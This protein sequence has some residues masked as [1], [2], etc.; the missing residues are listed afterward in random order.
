MTSSDCTTTA[1]TVYDSRDEN[2]YLVQKLSD[3]KCWMLDNLRLGSTSTI[4]LTSSNTNLPSGV[5]W[6]LPA[7]GSW[8]N[9]YGTAYINSS[10]KDKTS[11]S[12]GSGSGKIG[13]YYNY[14][15]ASAGNICV[16]S[17]SN[18]GSAD[19]DICPKGWRMPT[20]GSSGEYQALYTAYSSNASNFRTA[21]S[22]PLSGYFNG[23][24]ATNQGSNGYFWSS[25][26]YGNYYMYNL[27]VNS[28]LVSPS[29][30][31]NRD[32]GGSVRCVMTPPPTI[33]DATYMQDVTA[34]MAENT[35]IGVSK[36]LIDSR[37]NNQ[38]LV[39]KLADGKI[40]M[41]DNLRLG[42]TSTISL[43][44]S[45]TNLPSGVTWTL[46]ASGS[47]TNSYGTAYINSS[48]KDKTST[49]YGSG[50]GKIGVY[51]NYCAASAG[52][53]CV[54]SNS[55]NGSAD[56]DICPKGWRMPTGG[57]SGEYQALYTA[58]SSNASNFRTALSTPL[59]GYFDNGS[60]Y[61]QGSY[62][63]FWSSTRFNN[64]IMYD[65]GVDSS[66]VYPT[67]NNDRYYGSSV[68]CVLK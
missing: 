35:E 22:T 5:T 1:K 38:Y 57:S 44:S 27:L 2:A 34:E 3:N 9:S 31:N 68:R 19:R 59:S 11:T 67:S 50:S 65:L 29:N 20:G 55:N 36:T 60:A 37:D 56:R 46:P 16:S 61:S 62:G 6:T 39:A 40:W 24:S 32:Y 63:N 51:Y 7:S 41:L 33:A 4:S 47:W 52:N 53:I 28:S 17:N 66:S 54:S 23:G 25:T 48:D 18:N 58:Y 8:T 45:N 49:S 21:L 13:V 12:Y 43:T 14:C 10:D 26:R 15:A 30:Y 42:S 64:Y